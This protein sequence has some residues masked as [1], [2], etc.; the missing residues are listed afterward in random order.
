[1]QKKYRTILLTL[2]IAMLAV[3]TL[4][5][6]G[7]VNLSRYTFKT[8]THTSHHSQTTQYLEGV[9]ISSPSSVVSKSEPSFAPALKAELERLTIQPGVYLAI[10]VNQIDVEGLYWL[11]LLKRG[12]ACFSSRSG[13]LKA[14]PFETR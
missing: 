10:S 7:F 1:M 3:G 13:S 8:Q 5:E 2:A 4:R 6:L 14:T 9:P 12:I 11:P